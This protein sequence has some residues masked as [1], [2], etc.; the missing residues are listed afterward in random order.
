MDIMAGAKYSRKYLLGRNNLL[1]CNLPKTLLFLDFH[2][3]GD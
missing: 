2:V 1:L 3:V